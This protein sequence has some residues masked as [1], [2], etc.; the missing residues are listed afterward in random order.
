MQR[1]RWAKVQLG[2]KIKRIHNPQLELNSFV[3]QIKA[4]FIS[5][6]MGDF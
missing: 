4:H 3:R 5:D 2:Y 6:E 1:E